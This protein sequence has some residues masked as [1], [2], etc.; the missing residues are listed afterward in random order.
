MLRQDFIDN[1]TSWWELIDFCSDEDCD[2]CENIY[3]DDAKDEYINDRLVDWAREYNWRDLYD[4]LGGV[5]DDA[6]YYHLDDYGD[7]ESLDNYSDFEAY[8]QDVLEW[9]DDMERWDDDDEEE[10]PFGFDEEEEPAPAE[11]IEDEEDDGIDDAE[12]FAI[13]DLM[14]ASKMTIK[15]AAAEREAEEQKEEAEFIALIHTA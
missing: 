5:P 6:S 7:F 3:D 4:I 15:D 13:L 11:V 1:I 8:K 12:P 10:D 14:N 9:M 2:I